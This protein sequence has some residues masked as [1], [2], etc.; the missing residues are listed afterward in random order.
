MKILLQT[1]ILIIFPSL[2]TKYYSTYSTLLNKFNTKG[3]FLPLN[4]LLQNHILSH[5]NT[6]Q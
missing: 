1:V 3:P 5:P 6:V 2:S 4:D